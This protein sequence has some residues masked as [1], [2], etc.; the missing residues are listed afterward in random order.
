MF[1]SPRTSQNF[2][3]STGT[4]NIQNV[5]KTLEA[6]VKIIRPPLFVQYFMALLAF[7]RFSKLQTGVEEVHI[8]PLSSDS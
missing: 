5:F 3:L 4:L 8:H 1:K 2:L 6:E 7:Q